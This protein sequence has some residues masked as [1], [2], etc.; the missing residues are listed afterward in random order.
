MFLRLL[1]TRFSLFICLFIHSTFVEC[2]LCLFCFA[3]SAYNQM[4][5]TYWVLNKGSL[6]N[7]LRNE[8]VGKYMA[9]TFQEIIHQWAG[10]WLGGQKEKI[11]L[12]ISFMPFAF[13]SNISM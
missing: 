7:G 3:Y 9:Y 13:A 10:E 12:R 6:D 11:S 8:L 1:P 2:L 5:D 4:I